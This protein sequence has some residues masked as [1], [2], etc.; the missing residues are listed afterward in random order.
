MYGCVIE[1]YV[2]ICVRVFVWLVDLCVD[3]TAVSA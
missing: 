3:N 2:F 1:A